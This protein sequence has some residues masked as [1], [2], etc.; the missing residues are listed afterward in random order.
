MPSGV[1]L[2]AFEGAYYKLPASFWAHYD[3]S[4]PHCVLRVENSPIALA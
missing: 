3:W 4:I 2:E 1:L